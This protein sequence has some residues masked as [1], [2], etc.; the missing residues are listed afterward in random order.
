MYLH[1]IPHLNSISHWEKY[2]LGEFPSYGL[3]SGSLQ[4]ARKKQTCNLVKILN[5]WNISGLTIKDK[6][7]GCC[8]LVLKVILLD[9]IVK[10]L[11]KHNPVH[12]Q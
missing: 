5:M 8:W 4:I 2:F 10:I 7:L 1:L 12:W 11:F 6:N 3:S 9:L